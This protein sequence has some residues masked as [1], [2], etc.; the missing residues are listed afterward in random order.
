MSGISM[1]CPSCNI[2][3]TFVS[4]DFLIIV[5]CAILNS[6]SI[7]S[8]ERGNPIFRAAFGFKVVELDHLHTLVYELLKQDVNHKF[9]ARKVG[10]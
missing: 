8:F 9:R 10:F 3:E 2:K 1:M 4:K 5:P 6:R 7:S